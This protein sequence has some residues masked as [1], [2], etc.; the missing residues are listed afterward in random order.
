MKIFEILDQ[1]QTSVENAST[2]PL[3]NKIMLDRDE[4]LD[5]IDELR[6]QIPAQV[7][8]AK[9]IVEEEARIKQTAQRKADGLIE[10]A[11]AQKQHLIDTN[12]ITKNAYEEADE[13]VG[14]AKAEANRMR[15]RSIEYVTNLLS[16]AQDDLRDIITVIDENKSE[17]KDK[18]KA[19]TNTKT[20]ETKEL[21]K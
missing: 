9:R 15:I 11:R 16:K 10:D 12:N 19:A 5:M 13:I 17:M 7:K 3:T 21:K 14:S 8:E 1:L 4:L 20:L 18:K 2:V 6:T